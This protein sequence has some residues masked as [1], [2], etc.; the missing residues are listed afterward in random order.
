V[1]A[2]C[3]QKHRV[4]CFDGTTWTAS[5]KAVHFDRAA[6]ACPAG[7]HFDVPWNGWE[8]ARLRAAAGPADDVWL[9]YATDSTGWHK[10]S[11]Y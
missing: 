7:A 4:A 1:S 3:T 10:I 8:N 5:R 2:P 9:A 6:D 11:S